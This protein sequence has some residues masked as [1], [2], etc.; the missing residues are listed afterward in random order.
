VRPQLSR[1]GLLVLAC[2]ALLPPA[3]AQPSPAATCPRLTSDQIVEN[4]VRRN[5]DRGRALPAFRSTR[6]YRAEYRGFPGSRSAE[7]VVDMQY[8]P[9][10]AKGFSIRSQ[11]GSKLII[12]RVFKKLL[13]AEKEASDAEN[14]RRTALNAENY[15]FAFLGC[16][17]AREGAAYA[18]SVEPKVPSKFL[19]RGKILVDVRDFAV[20]KMTG[21]PAKNPSFWIRQ[22]EIEQVY[23]KVDQFWLPT[24]NHS[25]TTVRLGGHAD[26]SIDYKDYQ[27]T[28]VAPL[29]AGDSRASGPR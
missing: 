3:T 5:L 22:T 16:E 29:T 9:P 12:D 27:L 21:Q 28:A 19:Y 2:A 6:I 10:G 7:M 26:L 4:L 23:G 8:S 18:L 11:T 15:T 14:Q 25:A 17:I 20:T 13:D 1:I 24:H